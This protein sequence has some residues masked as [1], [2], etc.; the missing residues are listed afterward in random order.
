MSHVKVYV[1]T[2]C[3][4]CVAAKRFLDARS[5]P[6]DVVD[7]T[8]DHEQRIWLMN[9]TGLRTVPQIFVGEH[10][11]G[12]YTDMIALDEKGELQ[13]LLDEARDTE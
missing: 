9:R 6:Y 12:G 10:A 1:T 5:V 2:Y 7:I 11:I 8:G 4:Y 3:P 13:P